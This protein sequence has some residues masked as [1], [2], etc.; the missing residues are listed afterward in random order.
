MLSVDG[1]VFCALSVIDSRQ[2]SFHS[3][4]KIP[5][6]LLYELLLDEF[7]MHLSSI[8]IFHRSRSWKL[9]QTEYGQ[10]EDACWDFVC[11]CTLSCNPHSDTQNFLQCESLR[12]FEELN[13]MWKPCHSSR[14]C[15]LQSSSL[16]ASFCA[17]NKSCRSWRSFYSHQCCKWNFSR[18]SEFAC[19]AQGEIS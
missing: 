7:A 8:E 14:S 16:G 3:F 11:A 15:I 12:A 6:F 17:R 18:S 9:F 2:T 10:L 4:H 5:S 1:L 13:A 19:E